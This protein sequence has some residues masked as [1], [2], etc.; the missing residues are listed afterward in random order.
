MKG[1]SF[2][3]SLCL[4]LATSQLYYGVIAAASVEFLSV[5]D[6]GSASLGGYHLHNAAG[7]AAA[8][9][10]YISNDVSGVEFILNTGDNFYYCGIQNTSD[11]QI[12][13]D[14]NCS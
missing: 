7:T 8:M 10:T 14:Y 1:C 4:L 5:G 9:K 12:T 6:W 3:S 11:P 13:E 2:M